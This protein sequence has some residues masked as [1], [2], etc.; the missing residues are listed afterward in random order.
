MEWDYE[1][2]EAA[3]CTLTEALG[4]ICDVEIERIEDTQRVGHDGYPV[5]ECFLD[6]V[7]SFGETVEGSQKVIITITPKEA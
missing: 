4:T 7:S 2:V 1:K 6:Q 3:V 5:E